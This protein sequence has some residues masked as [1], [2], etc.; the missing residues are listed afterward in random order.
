MPSGCM[1]QIWKTEVGSVALNRVAHPKT[2]VK[3]GKCNANERFLVISEAVDPHKPS[4]IW[5][6]HQVSSPWVQR[7]T[8]KSLEL[9]LNQGGTFWVARVTFFSE[10]PK[11]WRKMRKMQG[12]W[13]VLKQ[14]TIVNPLE[15]DVLTRA[16]SLGYNEVHIK[17]WNSPESGRQIFGSKC[18]ILLVK[19]PK[20]AP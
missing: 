12:F 14:W 9:G 15:F 3:W 17:V 13:R 1:H 5:R 7:S 11:N 6:P 4:E 20:I 18:K 8:Y 16:P 19:N 10:K 2:G